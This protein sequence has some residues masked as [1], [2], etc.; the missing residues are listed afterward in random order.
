MDLAVSLEWSRF[1]VLMQESVPIVWLLELLSLF[2]I[3]AVGGPGSHL[4]AQVRLEEAFEEV[5]CAPA[6]TACLVLC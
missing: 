5:N 6:D 4:T 3:L 1:L 2:V